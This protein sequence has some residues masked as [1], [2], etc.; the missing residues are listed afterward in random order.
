MKKMQK[1]IAIVLFIAMV[2]CSI[3][4]STWAGA[5]RAKKVTIKLNKTSVTIK[6]GKKTTLKIKTKNIK[7]LRSKK[8]SVK[9][10]KIAQVTKKGI[11]R[12]VKAGKTTVTCKIKYIAKGSKKT[13]TKRLKCTITVTKISNGQT[14]VR[15]ETPSQ[16]PSVAPSRIPSVAPSQTPSVAPSQTP[17]VA[18]SQTPSVA[19]SQ[20]P[21]VAPSQTPSVAPT[22]SAAAGNI[23]DGALDASTLEDLEIEDDGLNAYSI[24][25][26]MGLGINLGNTFESCG[27]WIDSSSVTK[28]ETAWGSPVITRA[29]I[30]GMKD[31]GF[32]SVRI[33]V[34]WSN[35]MTEDPST[36][37]YTINSAYFE[38]V[39]EV[40]NYVLDAGMYAIINIHFDSGWW[41]RFGSQDSTERVQ[42]MIKYKSMWQQIAD[43]FKDYDN[44]LIFESANEEL[45]DRLNSTDDYENSGYYSTQEELYALTNQINQT[46]VSIVRHS[47]GNNETRFLLIAGYNTDIDMT[48][49]GAYEM[50]KDVISNHLMVSIHYYTPSAYCISEDETNTDWYADTW[51]TEAEKKELQ[52][53]LNKMKISFV[54]K[55]YPVIIGEYGVVKKK[56]NRSDFMQA[57]IEYAIGNGMCPV[58]WDAMSESN[59]VYNRNTCEITDSVDQEMFSMMATTAKNTD[60]YQ[61]DLTNSAPVWSGTIGNDGWNPSAPEESENNQNTMIL[62]QSGG[63]YVINQ[64]DWSE[65]TNPVLTLKL[66]SPSD[67]VDSLTYILDTEVN[68]DNVYWPY[69]ENNGKLSGTW[70]MASGLSIDLSALSLSQKQALYLAFSS[71]GTT[72]TA[73]V[74]I[75][76]SEKS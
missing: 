8:W 39:E 38:R 20:T 44:H 63:T 42:A 13:K 57:V 23:V 47:G 65:Y 12:G 67:A 37:T 55:G 54:D 73:G 68:T 22:P 21:S 59:Y 36:S 64:V 5:A 50:P 4:N 56:A 74:T 62:S 45:G 28:Y 43:Y 10:K 49:N 76:I 1:F 52:Q 32:N 51:G 41:A 6:Q 60:I 30:Q 17:N 61:P 35:M 71:N 11:V 31:A 3:G 66:D 69:I 14:T 26:E 24:V 72:F 18:P 34:A 16:I 2:S 58:L 27:T 75:T 7:K 19:P 29:M 46:F 40:M 15:P 53:Q 25:H 70:N 33:P 9:N 48:C